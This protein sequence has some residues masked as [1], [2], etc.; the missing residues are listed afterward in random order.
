MAMN[1]FTGQTKWTY[2][3]PGGRFRI[4]ATV[5]EPPSAEL[6][7]ER[8][9]VYIGSGKYVYCL[10]SSDGNE[11]WTLKVCDF[12]FGYGFMTF[13]TH[14]S[15][16]LAAEAFTCFSQNPVAQVREVEREQEESA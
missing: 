1:S 15:S 12:F 9:V 5:I 7:R 4:P 2:N 3:C 16:R 8:G 13:A 6:G 14:W 10:D 11:I